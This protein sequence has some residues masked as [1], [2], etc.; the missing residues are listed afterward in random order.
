MKLIIKNIKKVE[1]NIEIPDGSILV[2]ELKKE[3]ETQHNFDSQSLKLL[4]NGV[5]LEDNKLLTDYGIKS[6]HVILMISSKAKPKGELNK[7]EPSTNT[8]TESTSTNV[9]TETNVPKS[10]NEKY[11]NETK[12]LIEMG[13]N[14]EMVKQAINI[15]QGNI[16]T[17]IEYLYTGVPNL[18]EHH[19][20]SYSGEEEEEYEGDR[21]IV[22][23]DPEMLSNVDLTDPGALKR[24]VAIVKVI[25]SEDPSQLQLILEDIEETNPE[26]IEFIKGRE[27]EFKEMLQSP[28]NAED[29]AIFN[30]LIQ[31]SQAN[32]QLTDV[33]SQPELTQT[34]REAVER[35]KALGFNQN[36][37]TEAYIICGKNEMLAANL[38]LEG[39]AN[40]D[41]NGKIF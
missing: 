19:D 38:L 9:K 36:E 25:I 20:A 14:P 2:K 5:V 30:Q 33:Q 13:F 29:M 27:A 11:Q 22:E 12:Q 18:E 3:I 7:E 37:A 4:Y 34:D 28:I 21:G 8:H 23:L 6:G 15:A 41:I 32:V 16:N 35:L 17:A 10:T 39:K 31:G 26:I 24:I 40:G 1:Y